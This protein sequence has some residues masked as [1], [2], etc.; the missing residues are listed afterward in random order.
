MEGRDG[1]VNLKD[2]GSSK[3]TQ[4]LRMKTPHAEAYSATHCVTAH[5][6]F[7][8]CTMCQTEIVANTAHSAN[9][10]VKRNHL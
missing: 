2:N 6:V 8:P 4:G 10:T 1:F 5:A 7:A 9:G 3:E